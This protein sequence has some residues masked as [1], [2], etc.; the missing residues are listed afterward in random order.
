MSGRSGH[1]E[2]EVYMEIPRWPRAGAVISGTTGI[3]ISQLHPF[4]GVNTFVTAVLASSSSSSCSQHSPRIISLRVSWLDFRDFRSE[5]LRVRRAVD[6]ASC[7]PPVLP[8][9]QHQEILSAFYAML[10][11]SPLRAGPWNLELVHCAAV[12]SATSTS[13]FWRQGGRWWGRVH[14]RHVITGKK[15]GVG[16][17]ARSLQSVKYWRSCI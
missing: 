16:V 12:K 1:Q 3:V 14:C 13:G 6:R 8:F 11:L 10:C 9:P 4:P 2:Q 17:I 5:G 7:Q 15:A